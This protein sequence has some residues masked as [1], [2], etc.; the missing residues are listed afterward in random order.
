M[1]S[2]NKPKKYET[3]ESGKSLENKGVENHEENQ[4]STENKMLIF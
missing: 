4:I 3:M 1:G 2:I